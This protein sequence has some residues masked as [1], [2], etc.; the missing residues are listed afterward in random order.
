MEAL[1]LVFATLIG[2]S[3]GLLGGGG[4]VLAVPVFVYVLGFDAKAAIAMSLVVVGVTSLFG[5][6]GHW[7]AGH[8]NV[9]LATYFGLV[10]MAGTYAGARLAVFFSGG[11]QLALFAVVMLGAAFFMFRGGR[12]CEAPE[13]HGGEPGGLAGLPIAWIVAEGLGVGVLSGLVGVG[14]GFLIVPAIVLLGGVP[15]KEAVGTSLVVIAMKSAAGVYGYLG[16]VDLDWGF[17]AVFTAAAIPGIL[18]GTYL[19]RFVSQLRLRRAFASLLV[20][21]SGLILYQNR[22]MVIAAVEDVSCRADVGSIVTALDL[23]GD[24]GADNADKGGGR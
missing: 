14:G 4:S 12:E 11:A 20:V 18:G 24:S 16:M 2:L 19:V 7:R 23:F 10:A 1:A 5:A 22:G 3:L 9:R 15:M 6:V 21:M 17:I 8:V 13:A